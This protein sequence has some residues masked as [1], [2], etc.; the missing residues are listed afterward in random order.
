MYRAV[1]AAEDR[2]ENA[3]YVVAMKKNKTNCSNKTR[4][5]FATP[6]MCPV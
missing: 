5:G 3:S 4:T 1:H 2:L 6:L